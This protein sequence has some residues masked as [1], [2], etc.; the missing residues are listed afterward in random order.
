MFEIASVA[1]QFTHRGYNYQ[2]VWQNGIAQYTIRI[3]R[4]IFR[5][6]GNHGAV[7]AIIDRYIQIRNA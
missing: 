5:G 4:E 6:I 3:R 2:I 7:K 1:N